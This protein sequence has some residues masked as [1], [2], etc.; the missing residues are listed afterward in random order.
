[1]SDPLSLLPYSLA[2]GGGTI[3]GIEVQ[4]LVAAGFTLLQRSAPL[5]R[6]LARHRSAMLLEGGAAYITALAASDGR[7]ALLLDPHASPDT[8]ER[9]LHR[10]NASVVFTLSA[11]AARLP[12]STARV[13]LDDAPRSAR[14]IIGDHTSDV[15]LGSHFGLTVEGDPG[16]EGSSEECVTV[17]D[18]DELETLTHR[19]VLS[20]ARDAHV[21]REQEP[22]W[23]RSGF[24]AAMAPLVSRS[25]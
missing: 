11:H 24:I 14:V 2:A 23:T 16:V 19:D 18:G 1:M 5:V 17:T 4:Q 7:A 15:D 12:A 9:Q 8:I 25:T 20:A 22:W 13:L 6:A 21:P 10:A 3:D